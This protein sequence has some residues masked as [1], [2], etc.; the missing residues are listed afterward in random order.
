MYIS[1]I[2]IYSVYNDEVSIAMVNVFC[3]QTLGHLQI[4]LGSDYII[5]MVFYEFM[6]GHVY[7]NGKHFGTS[8]KL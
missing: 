3:T 8:K 2:M 7:Q 6:S 4:F 1:N 5:G